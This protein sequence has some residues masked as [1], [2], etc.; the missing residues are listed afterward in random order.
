MKEIQIDLALTSELLQGGA[1]NGE[2]INVKTLLA[3][4]RESYQA[5]IIAIFQTSHLR[6]KVDQFPKNKQY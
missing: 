1:V 5:I 2:K 6:L 4:Q 3:Q